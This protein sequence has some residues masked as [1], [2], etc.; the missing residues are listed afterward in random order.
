MSTFLEP[1]THPVPTSARGRDDVTAGVRAMA[2]MLL[3]YAPF[4]LLVGA[5]VAAS[6]SPLAAWLSTWTIYGGAAHLAVLEVLSRGTGVLA[7]ALVGLL[8]NA[9]IVAYAVSLAPDWRDASTASKVAAAATLT[10]ASW[11]LAHGYPAGTPAARR[12]FYFGAAFTLWVGWPVL[13]TLGVVVGGWVGDVP[14]ATLLPSL[15]LGAVVVRQLRNRPALAA[16]GVAAGTALLTAR[17]P[18][19]TALALS[20]LGGVAAAWTAHRRRTA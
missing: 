18:G 13:V 14:V 3:A 15:T 7:A 5:A 11:S 9:R 4:G 12:R 10:D 8:V 1:G 20:A 19:G 17:L 16:A 6:D 2:P